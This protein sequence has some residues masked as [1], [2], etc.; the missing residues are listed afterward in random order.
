MRIILDLVINHS[1]DNWYY[2]G[3]ADYVL[4]QRHP[5]RPW[6]WRRGDRPIPTE[7]RNPE[8]YH[9]RGQITSSGWDQY[10]EGQHGDFVTLKVAAE[11]APEYR[12]ALA[13]EAEQARQAV[14]DLVAA[15][16]NRVVEI[17]TVESTQQW[18]DM[19]SQPTGRVKAVGAD[20]SGIDEALAPIG[21]LMAGPGERSLAQYLANLGPADH[22][23]PFTVDP[24]GVKARRPSYDWP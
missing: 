1:G 10:P 24:A 4:Y 20:V 6:R 12:A 23:S 9:R 19:A 22:A 7:L 13:T 15:I 18:I 5:F 11:V 8:L 2:P 3:N 17:R 14:T 16:R 21:E